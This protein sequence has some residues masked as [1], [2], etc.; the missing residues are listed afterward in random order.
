MWM[1]FGVAAVASLYLKE[2][3]SLS[4]H[5]GR[6]GSDVCEHFFRRLDISI[7]IQQCNRR[8]RVHLHCL[9][10]LECTARRF[11]AMIVVRIQEGQQKATAVELMTHIK[12]CKYFISIGNQD[13]D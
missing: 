5:Q 4:M 7:L 8:V 1:V 3:G 10:K 9:G 2:D 6:S 12:L 11:N 13:F